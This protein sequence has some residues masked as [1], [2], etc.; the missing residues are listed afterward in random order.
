MTQENID[1]TRSYIEAYN[2]RDFDT[3]LCDCDPDV[4]WVLPEHQ[5]ADSGVGHYQIRRFWDGL[6]ETFD[7]L[8]LVPQEYVDGGD[9]VAVRLRYYIIGKGS[10]VE[11]ESEMYHQVTTFRDGVMVRIE[12]LD[13]WPAALEAAGIDDHPAL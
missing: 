4:E 1:K 2:R 13:S 5:S 12:Y 10:G 6:D 11:M 9:R 3:A 8:K 7:E